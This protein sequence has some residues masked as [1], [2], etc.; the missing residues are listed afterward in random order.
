MENCAVMKHVFLRCFF[1][2]IACIAASGSVVAA[3]AVT[4]LESIKGQPKPYLA[5]S[6]ID[7]RFTTAIYV[8]VATRGPSR[9]RMWVLHRDAIG[10][11][12]RLGMWDKRHWARKA[13][14]A[15]NKSLEPTYSWPISS[16]RY[17]RGD[18]RSGPTAPGIY[19]LD[20]RRWRY[21]R[22]WLQAGMRHVMHIDYHYS[23]GRVSGVAFH[24]TNTYRYRRLG[25]ADSH[26]CI[27][28]RQDN[29]LAFI[30]RITGR[31]GV[32][33][34]SMRWGEV[35]RFWATERGRRRSGYKRDGSL[36]M[37]RTG[38]GTQVASIEWP[39]V[40][41]AAARPLRP[42]KPKVLTKK[43]FRAIVIFFKH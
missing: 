43:G 2:A 19:G 41:D 6:E 3:D 17:Y 27:R 42:L 1:V 20:E 38:K 7:S 39:V 13:R 15:K 33:S 24:G 36:V 30:N 37:E 9:Q 21:G 23:G 18:R 11:A 4:Y 25:R 31:D 34:K 14:R 16:G 10:G 5:P 22:G 35:P 32:L 29:A 12:W 8:N 28:M 40:V 26:G